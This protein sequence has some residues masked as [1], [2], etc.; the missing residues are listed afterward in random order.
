MIRGDTRVLCRT[1]G[2][3]TSALANF[4]CLQVAILVGHTCAKLK[5]ASNQLAPVADVC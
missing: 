2:S 5:P 3:A 4:A 1:V